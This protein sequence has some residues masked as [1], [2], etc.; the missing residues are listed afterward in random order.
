MIRNT[1]LLCRPIQ[2]PSCMCITGASKNVTLRSSCSTLDL[3]K[4][5]Q[6]QQYH[7]DALAFDILRHRR[8][9]CTPTTTTTIFTS[10]LKV[11]PY[12][13]RHSTNHSNRTR[14]NSKYTSAHK[15]NHSQQQQQQQQQQATQPPQSPPLNGNAKLDSLTKQVELDFFG[16]P[17][18]FLH[19]T[20]ASTGTTLPGN[21]NNNSN[22]TATTN[23][24]TIQKVRS[25]SMAAM[26]GF[27]LCVISKGKTS[28]MGGMEGGLEIKAAHAAAISWTEALI[29]AQLWNHNSPTK[30]QYDDTENDT[31]SDPS[32]QYNDAQQDNSDSSIP[33]QS[34]TTMIAPMLAVVTV[35]PI[36]IQTG[37]AYVKHLDTL[38]LQCKS[39]IPGQP[40]IQMMDMAQNAIQYRDDTTHFN[41]RECQHLQ[42]LHYLLQSHYSTALSMYL[43]ILQ[44]CPGDAFAMSLAMDLSYTLGD[45]QSALRYVVFFCLFPLCIY[46]FKCIEFCCYNK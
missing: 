23:H 1:R 18:T 32:N 42:A 16:E 9:S 27:A 11:Q 3:L 41:V 29:A 4:C 15:T 21:P 30:N 5:K 35:A 8:R 14:T 25:N 31:D 22:T 12:L 46:T 39:R 10:P 13:R 19:G 28:T 40:C 7:H 26:D 17:V 45:K 43:Q 44:S 24:S 36:L 20:T 2:F 38:L 6:Q 34:T 37:I 33:Y